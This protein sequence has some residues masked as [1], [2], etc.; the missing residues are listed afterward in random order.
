MMLAM[1]AHSRPLALVTGSSSGIGVSYA[2]ALAT[3]GYDLVLVARRS[4]RLAEVATRLGKT[5]ATVDTITADLGADSGRAAV[6]EA[7]R[8]RP[9]DLLINNAGVAYYGPF[10]NLTPERA[11]EIVLVNTLAVVALSRAAVEGM[12][13]RGRGA[14]VNVASLLAFT[15]ALRNPHT[16]L[17][18]TYAGSKAF[19]VTFSQL[20]AA[21]LEGTGVKVQVV[22]P[23]LVVSEFH[24][25]QGMDPSR[26]PPRIASEDLVKGS[27]ADLDKGVVVSIP[28]LE[29]PS[30]FE[31]ISEAQGTLVHEA[32]R[33]TLSKRYV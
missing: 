10:A 9:L 1:A 33:P 5:G 11:E 25:A 17:R 20:L 12:I 28:T 7:C 3:R 32:L 31:R 22:C 15:G 13:A 27:L 2:E 26:L 4:D 16:P 19:M 8:T 21:E 14:I 6:V 18:A 24:T 23:G 29:E 30:A